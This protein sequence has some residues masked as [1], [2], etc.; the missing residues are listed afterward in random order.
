MRQLIQLINADVRFCTFYLGDI[1]AM[2]TAFVADL[3][4]RPANLAVLILSII[5]KLKRPAKRG[6][7][8]FMAGGLGFEPRLTESESVVLPLDDPPI[9]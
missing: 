8:D 6:R 3:F 1:G 2:K 5:I 4:L 7:F 9:R